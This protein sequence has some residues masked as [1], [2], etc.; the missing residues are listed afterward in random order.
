MVEGRAGRQRDREVWPWEGLLALE[1]VGESGAERGEAWERSGE[2]RREEDEKGF[3]G[4]GGRVGPPA[5]V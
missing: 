4:G 2:A 5:S 3:S 1:V